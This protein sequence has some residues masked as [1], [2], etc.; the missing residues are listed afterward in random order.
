[1]SVI[2]EIE[3]SCCLSE[4]SSSCCA[5][6]EESYDCCSTEVDM[7]HKVCNTDDDCCK[8]IQKYIKI[9]DSYFPSFSEVTFELFSTI[10]FFVSDDNVLTED[11]DF[12]NI[13]HYL[14]SLPPLLSGKSLVFFLNQ[15]KID[16]PVNL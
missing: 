11:T 10:H 7:E 13:T 3:H 15:L 9:E 6:Q 1:M 5:E 4:S 16:I 2:N 12:Q 14:T 8:I